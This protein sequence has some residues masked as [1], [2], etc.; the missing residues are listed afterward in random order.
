MSA[1]SRGITRTALEGFCA[2]LLPPEHGGPDPR[3]LA[4]Q[5]EGYLRNAPGMVRTGMRAGVLSIDAAAVA[6]TRH[7]LAGLDAERRVALLHRL[8]R[9]HPEVGHSMVTLKALV[10]LVAGAQE[11]AGEL[12]ERTAGTGLARPDAVLDVTPAPQWPTTSTADVVVIGSGAGGAAAARTLARK[13]L[14]VV[15][16][17]E[18]RRFTV[19]E[20]RKGHPMDRFASLYRDAG[21]T[22]AL[23]R[24]PVLLPIG[25]GV[26][27]TTLVNSGTCY[28]TP[29]EVLRRWRDNAGVGWADPDAFAPLLDEVEDLLQ[30]APVP[31]E[32]MGRNGELALLG[33]Q[34]LGWR[35]GPLRRNA[36]GCGGCC[37]CAIGCPRNAKFGVHLNALPEACAAGAKILSEAHVKRILHDHGHARGIVAVGAE[38][39]RHV[40]YAPRVVVAAGATETPPLLARSGLGRH[41]HLGHHLAVHPA[42]GI[43]GRFEEPVVAWRGVLQ[44]A[45]VEEFHE[46]DGILIEATS[47]PPGMGSMSLP[48]YGPE[49]LRELADAEHLATI[50]ALV[51]DSGPGRVLG[52][53]RGRTVMRYDVTPDDGARLLK[54]VLVMGRL[55]LAAGATEVLT[56]LPGQ[57]P[58]RS[59]DELERLTASTSFRELHLAAFHPTGT[60]GI[61]ADP[62]RYPADPEGRLRGVTGVWVAD[63][64][65]LPSSP[66]VNPQISIMALALGIADRIG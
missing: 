28:R 44:S 17:E 58:A 31:A 56:G 52:R 51:A 38:G 24:P 37:Q 25:R 46:S 21:S 11:Y 36:P 45:G 29:D 53:R 63:A 2:A 14:E 6:S 22:V 43:A 26:G 48:G 8:G 35:S 15:V 60:V 39:R 23:G 66:T 32:V 47:T 13:G 40:I 5:V 54:A 27:G 9:V 57:P 20:F 4:A 62:Q 64:S 12:R 41:P 16:V 55:L 33:A 1:R 19:D 10:L 18:G 59:V 50:G 3:E 30:V 61:G 7:R 34:Q 49:L 42:V 65:V